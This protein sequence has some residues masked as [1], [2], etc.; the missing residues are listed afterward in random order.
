MVRNVVSI[1]HGMSVVLDRCSQEEG[2]PCW[3]PCNRGGHLVAQTVQAW[4]GLEC[5]WTFGLNFGLISA[6]LSLS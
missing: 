6:R 3:V 2:T 1:V 5:A 4:H